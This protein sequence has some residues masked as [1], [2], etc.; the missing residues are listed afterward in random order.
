MARWDRD[1][2]AKRV[3]QALDVAEQVVSRLAADGY[4]DAVNPCVNVKPEKVISETGV[5]LLAAS[6]VHDQPHVLQK[7]HAVARLLIPHARGKRMRAGICLEPALALDF[8]QAHA[9]L[10]QIGYSDSKFDQLVIEAVQSQAFAG[11][12]RVPHRALEQHWIARKCGVDHS[13]SGP[14]A[15]ALVSMSAIGGSLDLLGARRDDVYAFTHALMFASEIRQR[16]TRLFRPRA[17]LLADAEILLAGCVDDEDYDLAGEVLLAWPLTGRSWSTTATF[18]FR[19]IVYVED[20]AGFLPSA[21]TRLDALARLNGAQ[22][23]NYLLASAYHT[24]FVMGLLCAAALGPGHAPPSRLPAPAMPVRR[25]EEFIRY[26]DHADFE[27]HWRTVFERLPA[28]ERTAVAG[29]LQAVAVRRAARRRDYSRIHDW[30]KSSA[31]IGIANGPLWSQAAELLKRV[32]A[33]STYAAPADDR[34]R[35]RPVIA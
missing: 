25:I 35:R 9:C 2:L 33:L 6:S 30:V 17:D 34:E 3:C 12:E 26:L 21:G 13:L 10:R 11:H 31:E 19:T 24:I 20:E 15:S 16:R 23:A 8:A 14:S 32:S 29:F 1:D 7:V 22:R 5:F 4:S 27:P 28:R 18:A